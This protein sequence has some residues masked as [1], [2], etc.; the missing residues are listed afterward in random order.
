MGVDRRR[1]LEDCLTP[2][3]AASQNPPLVAVQR[4]DEEDGSVRIVG[5]ATSAT[6]VG[7][8]VC[9]CDEVAARIHHEMTQ[10]IGDNAQKRDDDIV[11]KVIGRRSPALVQ[12]ALTRAGLQMQR[13]MTL[14]SLGTYEDPT[15][16]IYLPSVMY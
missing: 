13:N 16:G 11:L 15:G 4:T 14:M 3:W 7:H 8:S 5:Y 1:E 6:S 2:Q 12:W 9:E 10:M